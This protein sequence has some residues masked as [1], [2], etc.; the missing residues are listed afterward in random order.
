MI[1]LPGRHSRPACVRLGLRDWAAMHLGRRGRTAM[2]LG[3]RD[4][5]AMHL[6]LSLLPLLASAPTVSL[7]LLGLLGLRA[8]LLLL[9]LLLGLRALLL[10]LLLLLRLARAS[11]LALGPAGPAT[12]R[13][14]AAVVR[15]VGKGGGRC[16]PAADD[17]QTEPS[18]QRATRRAALEHTHRSLLEVEGTC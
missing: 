7:L 13:I 17:D 10:L 12:V 9:L 8:L 1:R 11:G 2:R 16:K 4:W 18:R 5:A 15:I 3:L 14:V 6:G